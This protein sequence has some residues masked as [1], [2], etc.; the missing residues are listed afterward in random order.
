MWR[1]GS[2]NAGR[3]RYVHPQEM[4]EQMP[5]ARPIGTMKVRPRVMVFVVRDEIIDSTH[6]AYRYLM[7]MEDDFRRHMLERVRDRQ[8]RLRQIWDQARR[9]A[10]LLIGN[11]IS[12]YE[13]RAIIIDRAR[14][15]SG[16]RPR[17]RI[18]TRP[19]RRDTYAPALA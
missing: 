17:A 12:G 5:E 14:M 13:M 18:A 11:Q 7:E 3:H 1:R 16:M 8:A 2:R 4:P 9:D 19:L 6:P 10:Q 15:A